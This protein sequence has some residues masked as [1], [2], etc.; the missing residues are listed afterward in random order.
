[1]EHTEAP[2]VVEYCPATQLMQTAAE[3]PE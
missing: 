2:T 3:V 1:V